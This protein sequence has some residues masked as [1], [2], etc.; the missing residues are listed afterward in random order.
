MSSPASHRVADGYKFEDHNPYVLKSMY[1]RT[2]TKQNKMHDATRVKGSRDDYTVPSE[3]HG[4][5]R[6]TQ[7]GPTT[8]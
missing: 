5:T 4:A 6:N 3:M 7:H 2:V 1:A 8:K